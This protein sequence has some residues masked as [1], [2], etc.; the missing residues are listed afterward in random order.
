ME[1]ILD[2]KTRLKKMSTQVL[3]QSLKNN[4]DKSELTLLQFEFYNRYSG[5][6]YKVAIQ[7]F[8]NFRETEFL[9][10]EVLQSVFI[11]AF[12]KINEF[13]FPA[14]ANESD[15]LKIIKAW[16]GKIG[17]NESKKA[18]GRIINDKIEYDS[19]NL[20]EPEYNQFE[21]IY[22]ERSSEIPNEFRQKLQAAMN[23]LS[24]KEK[25]I[26]L[27]YANEGCIETGGRK[28]ISDSTLQYLCE[29][30]QTTTDAIKQCKKRSLDKIKKYCFNN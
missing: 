13:E 15:Y 20:P 23:Q 28:H 8:R 29:Y 6:I 18:M 26:I 24:E 17:N 11:T 27:T 1:E 16:L 4:P 9:A 5:Y 30:Y 22:G 2:T 25:H 12:R 10:E 14:Q 7:K 19:L 21:E 3:V